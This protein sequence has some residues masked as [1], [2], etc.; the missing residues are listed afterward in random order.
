MLSRR[1]GI[2]S[3]VTVAVLLFEISPAVSMER[4]SGTRV[5]FLGYRFENLSP[6]F[7]SRIV[8]AT[9]GVMY[10]NRTLQVLSPS[11]I[12]QRLGR[13]RL[14]G[15]LGNLSKDSL[16]SISVVLDVNY[17][18]VGQLA[19]PGRDSARVVLQGKLVRYDRIRNLLDSMEILRYYDDFDREVENIKHDFLDSI[20]PAQQ[21]FVEK[22]WPFLLVATLT[23]VSVAIMFSGAAGSSSQGGGQNS[24]P[25]TH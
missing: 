6:E 8:V 11:E 13:E 21:G 1:A 23:V 22:Y 10:Q 18:I 25:P 20:L 7:Q 24:P 9:L 12:D 17:V 5:A 16:L 14:Q 19:N 4:N 3:F 2:T 15:L